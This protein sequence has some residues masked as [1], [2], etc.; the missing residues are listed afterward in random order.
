MTLKWHRHKSRWNHSFLFITFW[1]L[2]FRAET[3]KREQTLR[4][5]AM[6]VSTHDAATTRAKRRRAQ[7]LKNPLVGIIFR[8]KP[9]LRGARGGGDESK[10]EMS[11]SLFCFFSLSPLRSFVVAK[12]FAFSILKLLA[13]GFV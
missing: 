13:F 6:S 1:S 2:P 3:Q 12:F 10:G 8:R 9:V 7:P 11:S 4:R 5:D